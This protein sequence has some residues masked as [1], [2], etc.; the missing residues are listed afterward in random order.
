MTFS[1]SRLM[2]VIP[3]CLA[4]LLLAA[5]LTE[6]PAF[7]D[8][9]MGTIPVGTQPFSIA[10]NPITNR[11]YVANEHSSN[12]TV[13]NGINNSTTTVNVGSSA[14]AVAVNP[15]TNMIYVASNGSTN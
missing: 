14:N 15:V 6:K 9:S 13:I 4:V 1:T 11:I 12:V 7:N 8:T 5:W 10:L 2:R 3:V